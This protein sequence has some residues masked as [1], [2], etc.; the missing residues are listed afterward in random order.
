[1]VGGTLGAL[2]TRN[3]NLL[4]AKSA[5]EKAKLYRVYNED[6]AM[7][8]DE[9]NQKLK[10]DELQSHQ[11]LMAGKNT[12]PTNNLKELKLRGKPLHEALDTLEN[13]ATQLRD[14]V[15][16]KLNNIPLTELQDPAHTISA[17]ELIQ[18]LAPDVVEKKDLNQIA[19]F[20]D[21][22]NVNRDHKFMG[23]N[24]TT[25]NINGKTY[26]DYEF[27]LLG[28]QDARRK[29]DDKLGTF[30]KSG[31]NTATDLE[32]SKALTKLRSSLNQNS[33]VAAQ[34]IGSNPNIKSPGIS[35][36]MDDVADQSKVLNSRDIIE[37]AVH[38]KAAE[39]S[40]LPPVNPIKEVAYMVA[41]FGK[42]AKA[43]QIEK[44]LDVTSDDIIRGELP[45]FLDR[46]SPTIN[47][48]RYLR[49]S[50]EMDAIKK[51]MNKYTGDRSV[52][53]EDQPLEWQKKNEEMNK[54]D[55]KKEKSYLKG[56]RLEDS[57]P[58]QTSAEKKKKKYPGTRWDDESTDEWLTSDSAA[59]F[60]L[61]NDEF[62][63]S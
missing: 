63:F 44:T 56:T 18:D 26:N 46:F 52:K 48:P 36:I 33:E 34:A 55:L 22:V 5:S 6:Y 11:D 7:T 53:P 49:A 30:R 8:P 4:E 60:R 43:R 20:L 61:A 1:M 31:Y 32:V 41:P 13:K 58:D 23:P 39:L 21:G 24:N 47:I 62:N 10:N 19:E 27:T 54:S 16:N 40:K 14:K 17:R 42:Y 29:L 57:Y 38:R 12:G 37:E 25:Y 35:E 15:E 9:V 2:D 28:L 51:A 45:S 50:D 3:P 59:G